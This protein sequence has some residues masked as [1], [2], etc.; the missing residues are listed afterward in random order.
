[1]PKSEGSGNFHIGPLS[2]R[3]FEKKYFDSY[4]DAE[5]FLLNEDNNTDGVIRKETGRYY[6][7]VDKSNANQE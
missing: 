1:M 6:I 3:Q 5:M 2:M 7:F 4:S